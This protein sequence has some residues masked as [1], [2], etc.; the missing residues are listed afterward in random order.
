MN[1]KVDYNQALSVSDLSGNMKEV[2]PDDRKD[3]KPRRSKK[4]RFRK[5]R[6]LF[7]Q[8]RKK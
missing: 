5:I 8:Q 2:Y 3:V 4:R 7:N 1:K 6:T